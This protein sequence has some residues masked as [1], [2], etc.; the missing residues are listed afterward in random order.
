MKSKDKKLSHQARSKELFALSNKLFSTAKTLTGYHAAELKNSMAYA[1]S[2]AQTAAHE[3]IAQLKALQSSVA[4]EAAKRM[5]V[6]Q[7]NVKV[8]LDQMAG[9]TS[10]KRLKEARSILADWYKDAK[11]KIPQG[12]KQLG[13]VAHEIADAGIKA[14]KE[15]RKLINE[16]VDTADK[17]SKKAVE[18]ESKKAMKSPLKRLAINTSLK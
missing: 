4:A 2:Y 16:A 6:Y 11:K 17:K 18:K 10:D 13:Q 7:A 9:K 5:G 14:F 12:A 8:I 3:D 1:I 15:G